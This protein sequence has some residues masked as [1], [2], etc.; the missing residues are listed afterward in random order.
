MGG[1]MGQGGAGG[2][3]STDN[4]SHDVCSQGEALE[5]GCD[6]GTCVEDVCG[7]D[8]W[9]CDNEWDEFCVQTANDTPSCGCSA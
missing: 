7:V 5:I 1:G 9:C 3:G 4:C 6:G 8:T 2:G